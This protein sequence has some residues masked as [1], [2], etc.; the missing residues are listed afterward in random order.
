G[1]TNSLVGVVESGFPI[2]LADE[3][4]NRITPSAV[5]FREGEAPLVGREALRSQ[6][7]A[8]ESTVTSVKRFMGRRYS[9]ID[10][11]EIESTPFRLTRREPDKLAIKLPWDEEVTPGEVS[12]HLLAKLKKVAEDALETE[13]S[14]A[15]ITVPAYF[16]HPQREATRQAAEQAD[17]VVERIINEPT[18]A[19]LAYGLDRIDEDSTVAVY[20]LGGGTFDLSVLRMKEGVF[21]VVSTAGDTRLG[22]DDFDEAIAKHLVERLGLG[23]LSPTESV[24]VRAE[25]RK[26]KEALSE[27]DE[28]TVRLP[29]F[30]EGESFEET[31]TRPEFER[32]ISPVLDRTHPICR[33][34]FAEAEQ[35]GIDT[36]DH[37]ILVGGSTRTPLVRAR[38]EEWFKIA[39]NLSQHPD[40]AIAL[41]AAIQA[42]MLCGRVRAVVL[43][44]VTPLSLGIETFGG[45]MNVIIPRNSTIPIKAGEMFTNAIAN[46]ESMAIRILQ[47]EREMARDNW[48][49]G[50]IEVPFPRGSKGSARVGVQ[51]SINRDGILEVLA[52]DT[53]RGADHVLEIKNAAVDVEDSEVEAMVNESIDF[54]FDDMNERVWTEARL[55]SEE[56]LP[57]VEAALSAVGD[58]LELSQR[59]KIVAASDRV[60]SEL[61]SGN[62]NATALKQANSELD[63][64]TQEL[65]ALLV[66]AAFDHLS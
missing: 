8:A 23:V 22:G 66:E 2:V 12:A 6:G 36:I 40:E 55:K 56:L 41:G 59:E 54:A 38:I 33:R 65:A 10:S 16:N 21:E 49:L 48:L 46:Q 18:A 44:D 14:R 53:A 30:R 28:H 39:P 52:R 61:A 4:G 57:A 17:L 9:Q 32:L 7:V 58:R 25:A 45:L 34:A 42:G 43:V 20:D 35:K 15:V 27:T 60:R 1:T 64:A 50:E 26:A 5:T 3:E 37:L 24:Q 47:G 19:A 63:E 31:L 51:F 11:S 13:V 62:E 29:F